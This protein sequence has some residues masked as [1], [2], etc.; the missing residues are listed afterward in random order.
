MQEFLAEVRKCTGRISMPAQ[1]LAC[2]LPEFGG[3]TIDKTGVL[4]VFLTDMTAVP[5]ATRIMRYE[6]EL[7][8]RTALQFR[9]VHA[10]YSYRNLESIAEQL[11]PDLGKTRVAYVWVDEWTNRLR[12][13]FVTEESRLSLEAAIVRLKLPRNAVV[14]EKA[15]YPQ[16]LENFRFSK[17]VTIA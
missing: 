3:A 5:R 2:V 4:T 10:D 6:L 17:P 9:F 16:V 13:G 15:S 12:I 7:G 1:R 11:A 14:L 8:R